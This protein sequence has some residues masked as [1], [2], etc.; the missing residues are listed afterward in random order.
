MTWSG[1]GNYSGTYSS[2]GYYSNGCSHKGDV[3]VF[4]HEG[5]RYYGANTSIKVTTDTLVVID[6]AGSVTKDVKD[7]QSFVDGI[8][9]PGLA[10]K[11]KAV[12]HPVKLLRLN[13]PDMQVPPPEIGLE[14]WQSL[15]KAM[16]QGKIVV[17][18]MGGH[19]RTGSCLSALMIAAGLKSAPNAINTVRLMHCVKAV[20]TQGQENYLRALAVAAG[21]DTQE[22]DQALADK[23]N[24]IVAVKEAPKTT[25][26][27]AGF[28]P[29]THGSG[30]AT[31][32]AGGGTSPGV[33]A[34]T[35]SGIEGGVGMASTAPKGGKNA[36][37]QVLGVNQQ[38]K[39]MTAVEDQVLIKVPGKGTA[40]YAYVR[41]SDWQQGLFGTVPIFGTRLAE[42]PPTAK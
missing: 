39:W 38:V 21:T 26:Q 18:C 27:G 29:I 22:Y 28:L 16:P 10:K 33:S 7:A 37:S 6:L 30:T 24:L 2:G 15:L 35:G 11:L 9:D 40:I 25:V 12:A 42:A 23:V 14:F 17:A 32:T 4:E 8:S 41:K 5:R 20:E 31:L 34:G 13:W 19:G 36:S 3:L 1:S